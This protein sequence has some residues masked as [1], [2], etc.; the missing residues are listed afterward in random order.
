MNLDIYMK[1]RDISELGFGRRFCVWV[2]GC[3]KSC[4]GCVAGGAQSGTGGDIISTDALAWEIILSGCD[5]LT[6]SG[7]EPFLQAEALSELI[8]AVKRKRD[9]GVIIYSGYLLEELVQRED[10]R[11]LLSLCDLLIDGEYVKALDD[12]LAL[13]GSSNQ[14]LH[15]LTERY[16][17]QL[18][19]YEGRQREQKVIVHGPEVRIIGIPRHDDDE[20]YFTGEDAGTKSKNT[21][22]KGAEK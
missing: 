9:I 1:E 4:P 2:N 19:L 12:N 11:T 6:I 15:L 7:G 21:C 14:R 16:A 17:D 13:R 18:S 8:A 3:R 22:R 5:G 20:G 10:A